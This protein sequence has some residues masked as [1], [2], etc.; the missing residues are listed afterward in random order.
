MDVDA[1]AG[2]MGKERT[3]FRGPYSFS[4][5]SMDV[6]YDVTKDGERFLMVRSD[7]PPGAQPIL[8]ITNFFAVLTSKVPK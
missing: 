1:A 4:A 7:E 6:S 2:R 3:L 5:Y 8:V